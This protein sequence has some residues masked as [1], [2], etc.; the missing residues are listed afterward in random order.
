M[1]WVKIYDKNH[2]IICESGVKTLY[3]QPG[4]FIESG[5]S[6]IFKPHG[7]LQEDNYIDE[8]YVYDPTNILTKKKE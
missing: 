3:K 1:S 5:H 7:P 6:V 2:N 4:E 8:D